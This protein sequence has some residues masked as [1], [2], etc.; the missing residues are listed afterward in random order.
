[1]YIFDI[2]S[3]MEGLPEIRIKRGNHYLPKVS[4]DDRQTDEFIIVTTKLYS[5]RH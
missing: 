2:R 5:A 3:G 1:M 4:I